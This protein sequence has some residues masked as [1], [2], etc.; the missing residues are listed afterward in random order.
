MEL[1]RV[2]GTALQIKT[3]AGSLNCALAELHDAWWNAI[4]RAME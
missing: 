1:G 3:S 4:A 2:G